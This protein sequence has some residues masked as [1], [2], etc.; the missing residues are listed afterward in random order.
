MFAL[1]VQS[2]LFLATTVPYILKH[3]VPGK[4]IS[5]KVI[6]TLNAALP[7]AI[8]TVMVCSNIACAG[9][10]RAK[11]IHVLDPGK[12]KAA[13]DVSICCFDKTGTLTGNVVSCC[14]FY[15]KSQS[16]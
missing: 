12:L 2:F 13:A 5:L 6:A 3:P 7:I 16:S 9:K 15:V 8:P 1:G 10:L 14:R 11:G 4:D